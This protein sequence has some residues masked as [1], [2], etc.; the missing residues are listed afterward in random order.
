MKTEN[1]QISI[2]SISDK[3][4]VRTQEQYHEYLLKKRLLDFGIVADFD[5]I[6]PHGFSKKW[7]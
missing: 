7:S 2:F 4:T 6:L 3:D 5:K 1:S